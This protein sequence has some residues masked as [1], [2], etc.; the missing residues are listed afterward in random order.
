MAVALSRAVPEKLG[1]VAEVGCGLGDILN[2]VQ[3]ERRLG[4]DVDRSVISWARFLQRFNGS[5]TEFAVGGFDALARSEPEVIDLLIM[6]GWFHYMPDE[7][8]RD[9]L[10]HLFGVKRVRYL[11]VDEFPHQ[12]G[13]IAPLVGPFGIQVERRH[14]WQDDKHLFLYRCAA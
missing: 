4:F 11:M 10:H 13:R 9:Q 1:V 3:A 8:I 2:R 7:W 12:R 14:D 6:A 5:A